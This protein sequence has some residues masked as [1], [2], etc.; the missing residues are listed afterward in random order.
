MI[1]LAVL[2]TASPEIYG[3][4]ASSAGGQ[5]LKSKNMINR[6]LMTKINDEF[7]SHIN[8]FFEKSEITDI[9]VNDTVF[10]RDNLSVSV[11]TYIA[12]ENDINSMLASQNRNYEDMSPLNIL[13]DDGTGR[14][15]IIT[16]ILI[17]SGN[18]STTQKSL[19]ENS[20][21]HLLL[22]NYLRNTTFASNIIKYEIDYGIPRNHPFS[23]QNTYST[24]TITSIY[25]IK[26]EE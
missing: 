16:Y 21:M 15:G 12:S 7:I 8:N 6:E 4:P 22:L 3:V 14:I 11:L 13:N 19:S 25:E 17:D 1:C 20:W 26:K 10:A 5:E 18:N 24:I 23:N 9:S 2:D